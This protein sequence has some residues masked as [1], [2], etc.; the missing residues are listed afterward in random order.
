MEITE[1]IS[2]KTVKIKF[3]RPIEYFLEILKEPKETMSNTTQRRF[4]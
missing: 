2:G 4:K 1:Q 3:D